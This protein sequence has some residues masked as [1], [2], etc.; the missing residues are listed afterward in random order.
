MAVNMGIK[1][2]VGIT[3]RLELRGFPAGKKRIRMRAGRAVVIFVRPPEGGVREFYIK[4]LD[5]V[6][7]PAIEAGSNLVEE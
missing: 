5:G 6:W 2:V 3:E 7:V 1:V 4:E